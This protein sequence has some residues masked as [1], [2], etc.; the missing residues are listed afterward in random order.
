MCIRDSIRTISRIAGYLGLHYDPVHALDALDASDERDDSG[1]WAPDGSDSSVA[2]IISV[3]AAATHRD[4]RDVARLLT[5]PLPE[6]DDAL[7]VF[8]TELTVLEK[9]VRGT[10]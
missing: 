3:A 7:V 2:A 9:E 1:V 4:A 10:P 5:G 6:G 8:T